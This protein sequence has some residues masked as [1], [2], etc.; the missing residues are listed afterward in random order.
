MQKAKVLCI[1]VSFA[2]SRKPTRPGICF[3]EKCMSTQSQAPSSRVTILPSSSPLAFNFIM[4]KKALKIKV[5]SK[6]KFESSR[7][8]FS[9]SVSCLLCLSADDEASGKCHYKRKFFGHTQ[10][11]PF[12][13]VGTVSCRARRK[14][15]AKCL[16]IKAR[17]T[18]NRLSL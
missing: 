5:D 7:E 11:L 14:K 9:S 17:L 13:E 8:G 15:A 3:S 12:S 4:R 6:H 1:V 10:G 16:Q 18:Q 2:K